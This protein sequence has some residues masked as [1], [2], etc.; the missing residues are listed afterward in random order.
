MKPQKNSYTNEFQMTCFLLK[1]YQINTFNSV[2]GSKAQKL[3]TKIL[4]KIYFWQI[5]F[6]IL[7]MN[8]GTL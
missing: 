7:E 3:A 6:F 2:L 1:N 4:S 5:L 8:E